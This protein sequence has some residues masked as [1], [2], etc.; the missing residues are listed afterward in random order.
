M[1]TQSYDILRTDALG[2]AIRIEAVADLDSARARI[3]HL[4]ERFPGEYVVFHQ[5]TARV[6]AN[7]HFKPN[8][9]HSLTHV[10]EDRLSG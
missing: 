2:Q 7:F 4:A 6:V 1:Q 5:A 3:L 8:E 10:V 9:F